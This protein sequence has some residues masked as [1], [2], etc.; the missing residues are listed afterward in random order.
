[1]LQDLIF[2]NSGLMLFRPIGSIIE[3]VSPWVRAVN[4]TETLFE[5]SFTVDE[6]LENSTVKKCAVDE[7]EYD[8]NEPNPMNWDLTDVLKQRSKRIESST[9]VESSSDAVSYFADPEDDSSDEEDAF[10]NEYTLDHEHF[11]HF[12]RL[13]QESLAARHAV[14]PLPT[15]KQEDPVFSSSQSS[16]PRSSSNGSESTLDRSPTT[17]ESDQDSYTCDICHVSLKL[18]SYLTRHMKKHR[19]MLPYKC[20]YHSANKDRDFKTSWA[21]YCGTI[22]HPTG[23]FSRRDTLKM[24][25]KARHFIYPMGTRFK[26]RNTAPGR[27]AGCFTEFSSNSEWIGRHVL[28]NSC[29]AFVTKYK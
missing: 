27:C 12:Q 13:A 19:D 9:T 24:H 11:L 4:S 14:V 29:P 10:G 18:K 7:F 3:V 6:S 22:C 25:L 20:P 17:S 28:N 1:M 21:E 8:F 2:P 5:P 23:S 16:L 15:I 26:D